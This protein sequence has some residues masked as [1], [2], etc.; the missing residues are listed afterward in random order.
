MALGM[1]HNQGA[2]QGLLPEGRGPHPQRARTAAQGPG[3]HPLAAGR[4]EGD[5]GRIAQD[6]MPAQV[7]NLLPQV[8]AAQ[9][10]VA[11]DVHPRSLRDRRRQLPQPA[12]EMCAPGLPDLG[13][14]HVP[15]HRER[16]LAVGHAHHQ[17]P[18]SSRWCVGS[19]ASTRDAGSASSPQGVHHACTQRSSSGKQAAASTSVAGPQERMRS[20]SSQV[21]SRRSRR[22]VSKRPWDPGPRPPHPGSRCGPGACPSP[23]GPGPGADA[24]GPRAGAA[25]ARGT[26]DTMRRCEAWSHAGD[27]VGSDPPVYWPG[28]A[29]VSPSNKAH[30]CKYPCQGEDPGSVAS[31]F[32]NSPVLST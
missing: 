31:K 17:G 15:G 23:T 14:H 18:H 3:R 29:F 26:A 20:A 6:G 8:P 2:G 21:H 5:V 27:W 9:P 1:E 4:P 10:P 30:L 28:H 32:P 22:S 25:R 7:H 11:Q 24:P 16:M 13:A 12:T 19:R